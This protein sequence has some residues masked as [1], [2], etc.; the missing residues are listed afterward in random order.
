MTEGALSGLRVVDLTRVLAGPL[1]T[2][3][4]GDM[5]ADVVKVE[6]PGRGDDTRSWG[7]PFVG[8]EAAYY[9]GMNRNKRGITLNLKEEKGRDLLR[10]LIVDAD[11]VVDNFLIGTMERW[12]FDDAWYQENAPAAVRCTISGYGSTGPKAGKPGYDFILQA[13]TGLMTITGE[14]EGEPLKIGVA[15]VDICVGLMGTISVLGALE[16]ARRTGV[17][18]R[19]EV[20]LHDTGL[21]M[22]ANVAA[23]FLVSGQAPGRYGN[24]HPNI[25]PYRPYRAVDGDLALAIG[26]DA[27][28]R[29]LA[30]TIGRPEWADDPR[31]TLNRDRIANREEIDS[32]LEKVIATRTR[33]EWIDILDPVGITCGPINSVA[34]ALSSPQT[35]AREM[36]AEVAHPTA[37]T[38]RM[39]GTPL[40]FF[41]TP[42]SIRRHPPLLG[43]HTDEVLGELGLSGAEI[44]ELRAAGV[45]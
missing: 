43:E 17:G 44:E 14:P 11:V 30:E 40:R 18:Q 29:T 41:G 28:F 45:V 26:N 10:K 12:G 8:G 27:Q 15:M 13:E 24:G 5:G 25:V 34:E 7:P 9:L 22:L 37:G 42:A 3:L 20:T 32:R 19:V 36:V 23:N 33:A 16:S 6:Q 35:V 1:C 39:L 31:F 4:L 38:V 2:M 21:Q